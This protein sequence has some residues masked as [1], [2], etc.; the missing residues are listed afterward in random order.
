MGS[1]PRRVSGIEVREVDDGFMIHQPDRDR[2]HHLN[3]TAVFVF[4]LCNGENSPAR[5]AEL[6]AAAYGL[7]TPPEKEVAEV[8]DKLRDESLVQ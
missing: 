2:I 6:L 7:A 3:H 1:H 5:I 4:E 8:L